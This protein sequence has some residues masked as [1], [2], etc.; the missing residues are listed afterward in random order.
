MDSWRVSVYE[1]ET[2]ARGWLDVGMLEF[3]LKLLEKISSELD[4]SVSVASKTL[5]KLLGTATSVDGFCSVVS[6]WR[7]CWNA[8]EVKSRSML[9]LPV[10][11][12][13]VPAPRD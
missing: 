10:A 11:V 5:G 9:F 3:F 12:D 1:E 7:D 4:L 6:R 2:L 8:E 13:D